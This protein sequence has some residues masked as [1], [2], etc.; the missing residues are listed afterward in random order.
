MNDQLYRK[1]WLN[2]KA[3]LRQDISDAEKRIKETDKMNLEILQEVIPIVEICEYIL[4]IM[5]E[6]ETDGL[7]KDTE[8]SIKG[9]IK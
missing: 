8:N 4:E 5:N 2:L 3:Y 1:H 9:Y 6:I 7:E